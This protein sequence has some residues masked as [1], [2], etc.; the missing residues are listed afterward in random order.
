MGVP[1]QEALDGL[2][3]IL[4]TQGMVIPINGPQGPKA[5]DKA[6]A[7]VRT[8]TAGSPSFAALLEAA[9]TYEAPPPSAAN[10]A[11]TTLPGYV[12]LMEDQLPQDTRGQT[13]ALLKNLRE[14][15]QAALGGPGATAAATQHL[16][17]L[18]QVLPADETTL[19]PAQRQAVAETKTRAAVEAAKIKA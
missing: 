7:K 13:A 16:Q 17:Q 3:R 9:Q 14:L 19:T 4:Q 15:A 12:P 10:V 5:T 1:I 8:G 18:A 2:A 11:G 6:K